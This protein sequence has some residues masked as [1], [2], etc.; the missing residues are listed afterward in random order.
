M[1]MGT[2]GEN[3]TLSLREFQSYSGYTSCKFRIAMDADAAKADA[4]APR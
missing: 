2:I 4:S 3:W 1:L